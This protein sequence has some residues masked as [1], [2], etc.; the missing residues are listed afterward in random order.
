MFLLDNLNNMKI[1]VLRVVGPEIA[2]DFDSKEVEPRLMRG[3]S[4]DNPRIVFGTVKI[5]P[6]LCVRPK[7]SM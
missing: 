1:V 6:D 3:L 5:S 7:T 4:M 2:I